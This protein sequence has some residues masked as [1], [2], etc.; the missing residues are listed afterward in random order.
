MKSMSLFKVYFLIFVVIIITLFSFFGCEKDA[1]IASR[2]VSKEADQFRVR[3]R[4]IFYNSITDTYMF[5]M[6]GN[7]SIDTDSNFKELSVT[8][9]VGENQ[10]KKHFLGL[11]DNVTYIVEQLDYSE[12]SKYQYEIVF[13]PQSIMPIKVNVE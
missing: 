9:K 5:E 1:A 11:S 10:Y 8:A 12:V 7:I 3:R 2:N 4:V 13:K 6:I